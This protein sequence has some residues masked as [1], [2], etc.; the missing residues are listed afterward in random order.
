MGRN[1]E[2]RP[3]WREPEIP[4]LLEVEVLGVGIANLSPRNASRMERDFPGTSLKRALAKGRL[5]HMIQHYVGADCLQDGWT[6]GRAHRGDVRDID[7]TASYDVVP[8]YMT[9]SG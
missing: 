4:P 9:P 8:D 3:S 5:Y 6:V 7:E 2:R 1:G